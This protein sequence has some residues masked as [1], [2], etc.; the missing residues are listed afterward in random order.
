M[1]VDED[2]RVF[3]QQFAAM[4]HVGRDIPHVPR[5]DLFDFVAHREAHSLLSHEADLLVRARMD[6]IVAVRVEL[7]PNELDV[8]TVG[9]QTGMDSHLRFEY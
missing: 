8:F 1:D 5:S 2:D 9:Q 7:H 3:A 6:R 4:Q